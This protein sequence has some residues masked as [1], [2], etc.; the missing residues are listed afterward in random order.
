VVSTL[1]AYQLEATEASRVANLFSAVISGSQATMDRIGDSMKYAATAA[2]QL[3][4]PLE[5]ITAAL[6]LLY[7]AGFAASQAGTYLRQGLVR[8]QKPTREAQ[9]AILSMGL[10]LDEVNPQMHS[11]TE[12]IRAFENAGAGAADK[13]DELAAIFDVRSAGA[14]AN[15]IRQG[16]DALD[17]LET[18]ITGTSKASEMAKIQIDTFKGSMKLLESAL[19][20]T[21]IQ[22]GESLQPVLRAIQ[23]T[24]TN[25]TKA[26][27]SLP[28]VFKSI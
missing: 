2:A 25:V 6:G 9:L 22:I 28:P 16:A 1:N 26:F 10:T 20:E 8:L 27:N 23:Y 11:L 4:I 21:A 18:K 19:Q 12:V 15:L 24:L 13:G 7:N 14:F 5:Q 3:N 17:I